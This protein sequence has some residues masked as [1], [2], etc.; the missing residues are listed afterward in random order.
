MSAFFILPFKIE[1]SYRD[2][3][4]MSNNKLNINWEYEPTEDAEIR[5]QRVF[6]MLL[7]DDE[8]IKQEDERDCNYRASSN[9]D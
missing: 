5:L 6:E 7:N 3:Y 4:F 8:R 2:F 9:S 1:K